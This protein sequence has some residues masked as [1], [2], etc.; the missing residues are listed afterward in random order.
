MNMFNNMSALKNI[1]GN[2]GKVQAALKNFEITGRYPFRLQFLSF[3]FL[4]EFCRAGNDLVVIKL[5]KNQ[6]M[7]SELVDIKIK[8]EVCHSLSRYRTYIFTH[9]LIINPQR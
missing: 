3:K 8:P 5:K 1:M 6:Q 7:M 2:V 9:S 4:S